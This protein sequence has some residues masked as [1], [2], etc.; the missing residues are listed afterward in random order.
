M[1][2]NGILF[3][4]AKKRNLTVFFD[5]LWLFWIVFPTNFWRF[6]T[7]YLKLI[8]LNI[9][10]RFLASLCWYRTGGALEWTVPYTWI[11]SS[12]VVTGDDTGWYAVAG[13]MAVAWRS[14]GA[15]RSA[16]GKSF[17][18][19]SLFTSA[20]AVS[21]ADVVTAAWRFD[22]AWEV[23]CILLGGMQLLGDLLLLDGLLQED[24]L[25]MGELMLLGGHLLEGPLLLYSVL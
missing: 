2:K 24:L 17:A 4:K 1:Q 20:S 11:A 8:R 12:V 5:Y 9:L 16:A 14:A 3:R 13:R 21:T 18:S 22:V 19:G 15:E 10:D 7:T 6:M 23:C 25:L